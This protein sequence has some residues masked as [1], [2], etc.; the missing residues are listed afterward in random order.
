M[1]DSYSPPA[2]SL[3]AKQARSEQT[4]K[5]IVAAL[6]RLLE[7]KS[8]EQITML[9]LSA[10]AGLSA[11]AI[12]R[13]FKNKEALLPHIFDRYRSELASWM[14]RVTADYLTESGSLANAIEG[15]VRETLQ[16]FQAN[17][18]I[19]RTVHLY[20]RLHPELHSAPPNSMRDFGYQPVAGLLEKFADEIDRPIDMAMRFM[21]FTVVAL[22][23]ERALYPTQNPA[24][25]LQSSDNEFITATAS[26]MHAWLK[27]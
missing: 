27:G 14:E 12:Y 21:A 15:L 3:P 2:G 6:E 8:F 20:G 7:S 11:G 13:R 24:A 1:S 16:C 17:A 26:M 9:E 22:V 25:G 18:H 5:N 4:T 23:M 19:F 10:E